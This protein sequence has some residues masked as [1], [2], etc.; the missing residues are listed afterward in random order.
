MCDISDI[1]TDTEITTSEN[2]ILEKNKISKLGTLF[3][4]QTDRFPKIRYK[5]VEYF[6]IVHAHKPIFFDSP[7]QAFYS[8]PF[9]FLFLAPFTL[10]TFCVSYSLWLS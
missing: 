8:C 1:S 10:V 2:T 6:N 7:F 4:Y 9:P 5:N 3:F